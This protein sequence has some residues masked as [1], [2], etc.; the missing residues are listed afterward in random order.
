MKAISLNEKY[1]LELIETEISNCSENEVLVKI[2]AAALNHRELWISKGM[3]PGMRLPCILG[4]DG[5]GIVEQVG[6]KVAKEFVGKEVI[7]YPGL[8]WGNS[9]DHSSHKFRVL[10]MPEIGTLAEYICV[11]KE[12]VFETPTHLTFEEAAALPVAAITAWRALTINGKLKENQNL[13]ITGI[14]GGVA[15]FGLL[16]AK[17]IGANIYVT[18]GSEEKI[19]AAIEKGAKGGVNYKNENWNIQLKELAGRFDVVLDSSPAANLDDYLKFLN[20][21]A[22]VV[23]YGCTGSLTTKITLGKFFLKQIKFIGS[24]MGSPKDFEIMLAFMQQRNLKPSI[25]KIFDFEN[26]I[27]AFDYL[28]S[29]SQTGK[30]VVKI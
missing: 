16:F 4:A 11:P 13:L 26:A 14:G 27:A 8:D 5:A 28:A 24:T 15:Q 21:G 18:S 1:Q 12:N 23:Y 6:N 7:I 9:E 17:A 2:K 20:L 19:E 3:Y 25:A 29:G 10:G 30:V 22:R